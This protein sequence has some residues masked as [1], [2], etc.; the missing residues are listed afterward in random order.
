MDYLKPG[1][2][3]LAP[4]PSPAVKQ[5][6]QKKRPVGRPRKQSSIAVAIFR[7]DAMVQ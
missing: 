4:A 2:K 3:P 1:P 5:P 6:M 7:L